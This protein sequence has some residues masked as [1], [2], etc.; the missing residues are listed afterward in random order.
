[1]AVLGF[2]VLS[3]LAEFPKWAFLLNINRKIKMLPSEM[4]EK[5]NEIHNNKFDY[6]KVEYKN[7]LEKVEI[8]CPTHGS[9]FQNMKYHLSGAGCLQ[10]ARDKQHDWI[11]KNIYGVGKKYFH[12]VV[13]A[14]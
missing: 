14:N 1:L 7:R 13:K 2:S 12:K 8:V 3:E 11:D 10:C 6:S 5:A 9:F 4:L